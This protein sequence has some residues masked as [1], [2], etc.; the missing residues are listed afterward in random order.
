MK[1][2]L[3]PRCLLKLQEQAARRQFR[4]PARVMII[5]PEALERI[6]LKEI[7]RVHES[8]LIS[9]RVV[10]YHCWELTHE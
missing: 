5:D 2:C 3:L 6:K 7:T 9:D 8:R 1:K 4:V 10:P